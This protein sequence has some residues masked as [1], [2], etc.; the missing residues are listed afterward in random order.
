MQFSTLLEELVKASKIQKQALS[1]ALAYSPS[2]I[3]KYLA[4]TRLPSPTT[5]KEWIDRCSAFFAQV[6]WENGLGDGFTSLFP[7]LIP[8]RKQQELEALI[9]AAL[10]DAYR[11]SMSGGNMPTAEDNH[12]LMGWD[13]V[14]RALVLNMS[15]AARNSQQLTSFF[16]LEVYLEL[17]QRRSLPLPASTWQGSCEQNILVSPLGAPDVV[18]LARLGL[19]VE[20]WQSNTDKLNIKLFEGPLTMVQGF[21][22]VSD[23]FVYL[24]ANGMTQTQ[25]GV[26]MRSP[27]YLM[28]Y[29]LVNK[30]LHSLPCSYD[31]AEGLAA[32]KNDP[33]D[34][35]AL[36]TGCEG[37]FAFDSVSFFATGAFL[38]HIHGEPVVKEALS[39]AFDTLIGRSIPMVVTMKAVEHFNNTGEMLVPLLGTM[40]L[41]TEESFKYMT[42]Y[43]DMML[44]P[45]RLK[46]HITTR[47]FPQCT[48]LVLKQHLLLLIPLHASGEQRL[49]LL[50]RSICEQAV[51]ELFDILKAESA[52]VTTDLWEHYMRYLPTIRNSPV[53]FD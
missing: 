44:D 34:I 16:S 13:Q 49:V 20:H 50:P 43:T 40:Q 51:T 29:E 31:Q 6:F 18:T 5:N 21:T 10:S 28:E 42:A 36:L 11:L 17:L 8:F 53:T 52:P 39:R 7:M 3:S 46:V 37:I 14:I 4:G 30:A 15:R 12:L 9:R 22:F 23:Q 45:E 41:S 2:E 19:F 1:A 35:L 32:L 25:V 27:R 24:Q 48:I 26:L 47:S 33:D 38:D